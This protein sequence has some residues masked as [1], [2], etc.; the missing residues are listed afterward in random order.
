MG[1]ARIQ[2]GGS[3]LDLVSDVGERIDEQLTRL[4]ITD[5]SDISQS[6]DLVMLL[7]LD[8]DLWNPSM[9]LSMKSPN[10]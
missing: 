4:T 8:F 9:N 1:N 7:E 5:D 10:R 6:F 2:T 3:V